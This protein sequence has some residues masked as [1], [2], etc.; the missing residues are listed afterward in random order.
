MTPIGSAMGMKEGSSNHEDRQFHT[1]CKVVVILVIGLQT[2]YHMNLAVWVSIT[3]GFMQECWG[4][5]SFL[6]TN[7]SS[8]RLESSF[9]YPDLLI[10]R[11]E[12]RASSH[13]DS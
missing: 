12:D 8:P 3:R 13:P 5:T 2:A 7:S 9:P 10:R 1:T 4:R 11:T 6:F